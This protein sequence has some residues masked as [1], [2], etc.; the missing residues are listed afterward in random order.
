[1]AMHTKSR[2]AIVIGLMAG[3]GFAAMPAS[4]QAPASPKD[5]VVAFY[6][7]AFTDHRVQEAF[8]TYVGPTYTQHNPRVADG[9]EATIKFL[10]GRFA[11]NPEATNKIIRVVAEGDLVFLHVHSTL[12]AKDRGN[13]IVDIFRVANGKIVE[14]WDV[15]QP[16]PESA[17][18]PNTMF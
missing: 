1:M 16:V 7:M 8:D 4:A 12:N 14:H 11:S 5:I 13:A 17:A 15:I 9:P 2:R 3:F 10:S 6:R 18:N